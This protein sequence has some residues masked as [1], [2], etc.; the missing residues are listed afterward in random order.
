MSGTCS[1]G[2]KDEIHGTFWSESLKKTLRRWSFR[3]EDTIKTNFKEIEC[4]LD[5]AGSR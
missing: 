4:G 5:S 3:C 2:G 1:S